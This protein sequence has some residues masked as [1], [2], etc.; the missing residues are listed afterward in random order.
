MGKVLYMR[1]GET[2]TKPAGLPS[3]YTRLAYIQSSGTQHI[4]TGFKPNQ[5]TRMVIDFEVLS[6]NTSESHISSARSGG[7]TPLWTLYY[8][9]AGKYATR[10]GT[11]SVQTISSPTGAGRHLFDK[12]KNVLSIDGVEVN[13]V[14]YETFSVTSTL[15][16]FARNDGS[17]ANAYVNGNLY[18]C[19]IYDNGAIVRD[20]VPCINVSGAVG[21]YDLVG[22][23]FYG[24][25]GTGVFTG[26]EV[27]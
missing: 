20:F 25:A 21:L 22:K 12:N 13:T 15:A 26:S 19:Q 6:T 23:K 2:H 10:Y 16:I 14:T 17:A 7:S 5:D 11:G 24:N 27:A 18:S 4:D 8:S 3:G 1:K 9:S